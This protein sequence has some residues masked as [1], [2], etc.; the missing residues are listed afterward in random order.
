[1]NSQYIDDFINNWTECR[2]DR[3]V[4][5]SYLP[6][7]G[8]KGFYA[9]GFEQKND[10]AADWAGWYG[11]GMKLKGP[12]KQRKIRIQITICFADREP[13]SLMESLLLQDGQAEVEI[14][15]S[16]FR[17]ET[18]KE[19]TWR[20]V[21]DVTVEA[22][23]GKL[24]KVSAVACR[25]RGF[26][27]DMPVKGK[28]ADKG[29]AVVYTGTIFNCSRQ[30]LSVCMEQ[31]YE[32]WET[33][34]AEIGLEV[35]GKEL[36]LPPMSARSFQIVLTVS[37]HMLP[38]GHENTQIAFRGMDG[39]HTY[40]QQL[41]LKTLCR[42]PHPYLYHNTQGWQ[43]VKAK[44]EH[45]PCYQPAYQV[46]LEK[47]EAWQ[48]TPPWEG[49]SFCYETKEEEKLMYAAYSYAL[50]G[51][52][53]F[54]QKAADFFR[55]FSREQD[56]Y[57]ARK[58]G[59]CHSYVQEGHFFQHL[60]IA[61]D[62]I[63]D[64]GVLTGTEKGRI[65]ECFRLYM[66]IL[67]MH[68][69]SGQISNWLISEILGAVYGALVLQD[70][71]RALRFVFGNGGLVEQFRHGVFN[72]GWWFECSVGYNTWVS[73]MMLHGA[74]ALQPFG[75]NLLHTHFPISY[76][77][78]VNAIFP[79][80]QM[81]VLSGMY[82][83]KWGG[84]R[85]NY[86]CI[87]DMFDATVPFLDYRG[88]LFGISDSDEKKLAGA[89][90]GSTYD[91]AYTYYR[92]PEYI[93]I[94]RNAAPDPIF[95]NP[96]LLD[97]KEEIQGRNAHADN[98]G[99]AMLRS[100][101]EGRKPEEQIQAVL[102]YGS[103][104]GAHGHFDITNLLS[105]MRYGRSFYNPENCWWGYGHFMYKFYVQ[106]SLTKNMVVVDDKMQIPADNRL[107]LFTEGDKLQAAGTEVKTRWAFPPYGGMVYYQ[108]GQDNT[109][110]ALRERC[111]KNA[112]FLPIQE[113]D[114]SPVYG[115]M[116]GYTEEIL[117]R[118]VM[119]VLDDY[120]VIFDYA[121]GEKP[122]QYDSLLQI[123]GFCGL[124]GEAVTCTH[125]TEQFVDNPVSDGQFITD[126]S[127]YQVKGVS[128]AHFQT[129]F[130]EADAGEQLRCDRSN[131]N[132]P[133]VLKIDVHTAWPPC[134]EQMI[135]RVAV[136]DGWAADG[137]G[138]TIP[139]KYQMRGTD[140]SLLAEGAFDGWILGRE[141]VNLDV[142]GEKE[143]VLS[144]QQGCRFSELGKVV[145]TPQACFWGQILL[146]LG[147]GSQIDVGQEL[148]QENSRF[149]QRIE[150]ENVD[151]GKGIG[152]DYLGGRVT[153]VGQEYPYAIPASPLDHQQEGRIRIHL[154]DL[155]CI[156]LQACVG[157][158]AFAGDEWQ[159]RKTY[160]V[161]TKGRVGRFVTVLEPY[162]AESQVEE[163]TCDNPNEVTVT[164]R[165]GT[166]QKLQLAGMEDGN[167][168][169]RLI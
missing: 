101:K 78:E 160:A 121:A 113:G 23:E 112:C 128:R 117:Q 45:Y 16:A 14:P 81:K 130:T 118:R 51:N 24:E 164:L 11:L 66:D 3:G 133:G 30:E 142:T 149:E 18:V 104:G 111:H 42:L 35:P 103:H 169:I 109:K 87:K 36:L 165:D 32:G 33:M 98:I 72:D 9:Y 86:V 47:A 58:R 150:F 97:S 131:Y 69:R 7:R 40:E 123:K 125:H 34:K 89:H 161:R 53:V 156:G 90:M 91:L 41:Q 163:V 67:D 146:T 106:C 46:Y 63:Y 15:F 50:T 60:A 57:P 77:Q 21:T 154:E 26:Y 84:N 52:M 122:H 25:G 28:S 96:E 71:D 49:E 166:V 152:K 2:T 76:N 119:A 144:L 39:R 75:Y 93:P 162:E 68:I 120:I 116:S 137:N 88:V 56:G 12:K 153:I 132:E 73:S 136:Y 99:I 158:D 29:E 17:I 95:G 140:C 38:G 94:I 55:F 134:N 74:R 168:S 145:T 100:Q 141:E 167:P 115:E 70:M 20:Y 48:V 92:D 4:H 110:E 79:G 83:Q 107:I 62:M 148:A 10:S 151:V 102:R 6:P 64:A 139:L 27:V 22:L 37:E 85:K 31:Q 43:Q 59:C 105:I 44:I 108:D 54:A 124:E 143:I 1:M 114:D 8:A 5:F 135:G 80:E 65:N 127:W 157:V 19:N 138:Y 155:D 126:C 147:D 129:I 13:V 82:N 159:K 61:Y